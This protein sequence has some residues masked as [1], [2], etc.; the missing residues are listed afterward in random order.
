M[1][2][3]SNMQGSWRTWVCV[4][5]V[6]DNDIPNNICPKC[7]SNM[8]AQKISVVEGMWHRLSEV[9]SDTLPCHCKL[10]VFVGTS[11][12]NY[13]SDDHRWTC[14]TW[15]PR[16]TLSWRVMCCDSPVCRTIRHRPSPSNARLQGKENH[17]KGEPHH[18][19]ADE[20]FSHVT[21]VSPAA[22]HPP[23]GKDHSPNEHW[24]VNHPSLTTKSARKSKQ[25]TIWNQKVFHIQTPSAPS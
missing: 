1:F 14:S 22:R 10:F 20:S 8:S 6:P 18:E 11:D 2:N 3:N 4:W 9:E 5:K 15:S 23:S 25:I 17:Q 7:R 19:K 24:T 16:Q 13:S 21:A 12:R